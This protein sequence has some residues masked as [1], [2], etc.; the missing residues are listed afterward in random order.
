MLGPFLQIVSRYAVCNAFS[1]GNFKWQSI[2]AKK[3]LVHVQMFLPSAS[4]VLQTFPFFALGKVCKWCCEY[5]SQSN[6]QQAA[7]QQLEVISFLR[8]S[9]RS[10]ACDF[11]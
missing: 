2:C 11:F 3:S 7:E 9:G 10:K 4:W 8:I 1:P 6:L 5:L